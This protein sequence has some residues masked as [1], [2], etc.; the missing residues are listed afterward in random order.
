[1]ETIDINQGVLQI[2]KLLEMAAEGKEIIITKNHQPMVKLISAKIQTKRP[3]L[4]GSDRDG[5][6]I[7]DDF[8]EPK[9]IYSNPK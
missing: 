1:M 2:N 4:F 3:P 5:V 7:S 9:R 6:F 8:D